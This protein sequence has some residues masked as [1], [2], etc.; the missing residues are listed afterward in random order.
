M[1]RPRTGKS[2][3][4]E[5]RERR[6]NGDVYVYERVTAYNPE[7]RG[8]VTV[9]ERLKGKIKAGGVE[10]VATRPKRRK[11]EALQAATRKRTG[12]ADILQWVGAESGIDRDMRGSFDRGDADKMISIARYLVATGGNSLT[13]LEAWQVMHEMPYADGIS[14]DVYGELFRRVGREESG[15]QAYFARRAAMLSV[16]PVLAFDSTTISTYSENQA[17]ARQGFNRDRDGLDTI[18]LLTLYSVR[19]R[20]PIAFA[21]QPGDI[22]DVISVENALKQM[23]CLGLEKPMIVTDNGYYSHDNMM[24]FALRNMKFLML[25]DPDVKWVRSVIDSLRAEVSRASR[26]C[27]FDLRVRGA[28]TSVMHDFTRTRK[29]GGNGVAAGTAE[30]FS[31]RLYVHVFFSQDNAVKRQAAFDKSLLE[32][33]SQLEAGG[34]DFTAS[35]RKKIGKYL[36]VSRLGRG[37]RVKVS[38]NEE[39]VAEAYRCFGYFALVGNRPVE[40]FE[41]LED[42]R[43]REKIEE[44]FADQKGCLGARRP[45]VWH[46]DS[47]KGRLFTQFVALGYLCHLQK[48]LKEVREGLAKDASSMTKEQFSLEAKLAR[49][50][51]EHSVAQIL[52]WFDCIETTAVRTPAGVVRWSTESVARDKL[53]L[54]RLGVSSE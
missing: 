10:L 19:D 3:V 45:R 11:G 46:P 53:L 40:T 24:E 51:D 20:E 28:S 31:R 54:Q 32:L 22:P 13:R 50:L 18:K 36:V 33:K 9:S 4:G 37:G 29:R 47:L 7:T 1:P 30:S 27:P 35:A 15:I 39:A 12:T 6:K 2:H 26:I 52:D 41:A 21:K 23:R 5:R 38:F 14:E 16:S 49:W 42:Y 43:L 34:D 25:V 48:R 8:T 17:E 44:A